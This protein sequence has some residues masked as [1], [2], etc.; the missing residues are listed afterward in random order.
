MIPAVRDDLVEYE[1]QHGVR[2]R[3]DLKGEEARAGPPEI[4]GLIG[5]VG[6][7][8][9]LPLSRADIDELPGALP[10]IG[11]QL[12]GTE[13]LEAH[14]ID[15]GIRP[16]APRLRLRIDPDRPVLHR[17]TGDAIEPRH[18]DIPRQEAVHRNGGGRGGGMSGGVSRIEGRGIARQPVDLCVGALERE[19]ADPLYPLRH[20]IGREI[21]R[22][23]RDL[24]ARADL[25]REE[26]TLVHGIEGVGVCGINLDGEDR[27]NP[28]PGC[29]GIDVGARIAVRRSCRAV[30]L[31]LA[32]HEQAVEIRRGKGQH[33]VRRRSQ[34]IFESHGD[35]LFFIEL[36][37]PDSFHG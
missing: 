8:P 34:P 1:R 18:G 13:A 14:G 32:V 10:W 6:K 31:E 21:T 35:V 22:L 20:G 26:R 15:A 36:R 24:A 2:L 19:A 11:L 28:G 23:R 4:V 7:R 17:R 5:A 3:R 27:V 33:G 29:E 9:T 16:V 25:C 30:A 37:D 12:I